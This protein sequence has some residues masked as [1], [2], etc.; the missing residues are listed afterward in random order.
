MERSLGTVVYYNYTKAVG[1]ELPDVS[2]SGVTYIPRRK[3]DSLGFGRIPPH[4]KRKQ[5]AFTIG[6]PREI[7]AILRIIV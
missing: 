4:K 3:A 6:I 5:P 2:E 7:I 1:Q